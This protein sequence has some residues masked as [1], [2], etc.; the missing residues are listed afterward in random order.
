MP[1]QKL[2]EIGIEGSVT[3]KGRSHV[4]HGR[5]KKLN[6]LEVKEFPFIEQY[7]ENNGDGYISINVP[8]LQSHMRPSDLAY[9]R[10]WDVCEGDMLTSGWMVSLDFLGDIWDL[11][12]PT[13]EEL[14]P[15]RTEQDLQIQ[16]ARIKATEGSGV[17]V[18][19]PLIVFRV[20]LT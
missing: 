7:L 1:D 18:G 4:F 17:H 11:P 16:V 2:F 19:D 10:K 14:L 13:R 6:I 3:R 12:L 5:I 9:V 20:S 15:G 8:L